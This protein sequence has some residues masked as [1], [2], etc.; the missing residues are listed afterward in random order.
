ML[1]KDKYLL[2]IKHISK[3]FSDYAQ[4]IYFNPLYGG[5]ITRGECIK[6]AESCKNLP[7]EVRFSNYDHNI[8][9]FAV[10]HIKNKCGCS[11]ATCIEINFNTVIMAEYI[12]QYR[13]WHIR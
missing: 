7:V 10:V 3:Q 1:K 9:D 8:K 5:G 2:R 12:S 4:I 6:L 11:V 13:Y